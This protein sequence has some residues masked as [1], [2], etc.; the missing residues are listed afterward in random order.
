VNAPA[1]ILAALRASSHGVSGT[2]FCQQLDVSRAAVWAHIESLREAGFE[3]VASPHRGYQL[4]KS[5]DALLADDLAS[6]LGNVS[7]I[8]REIIVLPETTSTNDEVEQAARANRDEGLVVF[9]ESQTRGRGRRGRRWSSPTGKGLWF[10]IL[11]RPQL[12]PG[13]CTQLTVATATALVRAIR[14]V[15]GVTPEI[16]WPNDLLVRG[17]KLAGILTELSA[18]LDHVRYVIIGIGIDCNQT[19]SDFPRELRDIAT[20]LKLT[21]GKTISRT[22]LA[23]AVL[24]ELDV[25]YA[26]ILDGDFNSV[27]EEWAGHCSTLGRQVEIEV[28]QRRITGRAEAL[29][30]SGAL[31]LRTEHGQVERVICGDVI[32][33]Q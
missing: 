3:I 32:M 10:S 1:K 2:E 28:G 15:T 20:S 26:R 31:M 24:R 12:A 21:S 33:T 27:A 11:L 8:G 4:V 29:D 18:E 19:T 30:E 9:A 7:V 16:K 17:K 6:R 25:D 13:E 14:S 23:V 22:D 5:P